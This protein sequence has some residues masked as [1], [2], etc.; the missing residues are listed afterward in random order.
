MA[1]NTGIH[2]RIA[3]LATLAESLAQAAQERR[4]SQR[5]VQEPSV[6][7]IARVLARDLAAL[8]DDV[9]HI[10]LGEIAKSH[11]SHRDA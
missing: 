8:R 3:E 4:V 9:E 10:A 6:D 2:L 7:A 1:D 11:P 5:N